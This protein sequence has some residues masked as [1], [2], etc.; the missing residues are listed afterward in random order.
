MTYKEG[1][2]RLNGSKDYAGVKDRRQDSM[3]YYTNGI[4]CLLGHG[5]RQVN[6]T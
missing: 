5:D 4:D 6:S 1:F 3:N 2:M